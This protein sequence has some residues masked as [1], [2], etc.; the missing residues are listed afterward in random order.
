M[1][2]AAFREKQ[3]AIVALRES[4]KQAA[5]EMLNENEHKTHLEAVRELVDR[6][7]FFPSYLKLIARDVSKLGGVGGKDS[8]ASTV[9]LFNQ[10]LFGRCVFEIRTVHASNTH[11]EVTLYF[12]GKE[13]SML[14]IPLRKFNDAELKSLVDRLVHPIEIRPGVSETAFGQKLNNR[15]SQTQEYI[16]FKYNSLLDNYV[17][18]I[19]LVC[20]LLLLTSTVA[21]RLDREEETTQYSQK[22][23][24]MYKR[25]LGDI[26]RANQVANMKT[27][28]KGVAQDACRSWA[29]DK[30]YAKIE[31]MCL[32]CSDVNDMRPY[33]FAKMLYELTLERFRTDEK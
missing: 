6:L 20:M 17:G 9:K 30:F 12:F 5:L 15:I 10:I 1:D 16:M 19:E 11:Y 32:L 13:N 33:R 27:V 25:V 2:G 28:R 7:F 21:S 31:K 14:G 4:K 24:S 26:V 18:R 8:F 3:D 29:T 23:V 22:A